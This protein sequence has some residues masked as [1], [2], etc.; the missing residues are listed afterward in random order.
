[1]ILSACGVFSVTFLLSLW[2]LLMTTFSLEGDPV[3]PLRFALAVTICFVSA[4][5]SVRG[6][7]RTMHEDSERKPDRPPED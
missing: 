2:I 5:Q 4:F 3:G 1:M 6:L 7:I